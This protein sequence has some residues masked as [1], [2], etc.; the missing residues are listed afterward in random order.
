MARLFNPR[1]RLICATLWALA[2]LAATALLLL[3][4]PVAGPA[5]SDLAA[6]F[7]LFGGLAF[8]A[9][10]FSHRAGQLAGLA[11]AT[12]AGATALEFAQRL[13]PYR[14]FDLTDI[15]ANALGAGSGYALALAV[16]LLLIRP[17]DPARR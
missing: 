17:A 3:P 16:L 10:S 9:V 5:R 12:I 15:A 1:T 4:M 13:V 6:H 8:A 11:L 2:W 14:T 7:L